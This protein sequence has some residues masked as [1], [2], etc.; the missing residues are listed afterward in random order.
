MALTDEVVRWFQ[1]SSV[2][3]VSDCVH[4]LHAI[5]GIP[6]RKSYWHRESTEALAL[7]KAIRQFGSYRAAVE[8]SLSLYGYFPVEESSPI[9]GDTDVVWVR[10]RLFGDLPAGLVPSGELM[11]RHPGGIAVVSGSILQVLRRY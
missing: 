3:R 8:A 5:T 9:I 1:G 2:W 7:H 6:Y 4:W 10:D 11:I